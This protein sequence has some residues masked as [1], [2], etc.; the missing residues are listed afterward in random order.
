MRLTVDKSLQEWLSLLSL[1]IQLQGGVYALDRKMA[2]SIVS[3]IL[4]Q[5]LTQS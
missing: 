3:Q 4:I 2:Q 5:E 1:Q